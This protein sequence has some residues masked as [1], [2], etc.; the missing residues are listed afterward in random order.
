M[1]KDNSENDKQSIHKDKLPLEELLSQNTQNEAIE[2][3]KQ[4]K[5]KA[6]E[7]PQAKAAKNSANKANDK[8]AIH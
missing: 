6:T 7:K 3:A 8:G 1:N 4:E 2:K 5:A